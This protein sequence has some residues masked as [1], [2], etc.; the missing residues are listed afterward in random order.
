MEFDIGFVYLYRN[1]MVDRGWTNLIGLPLNSEPTIKKGSLWV[2]PHRPP[3][4][5][6]SI[7]EG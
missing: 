3:I 7:D 4:I 6:R 2:L 1:N 5:S